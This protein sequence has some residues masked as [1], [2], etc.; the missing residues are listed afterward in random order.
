MLD[1]EDKLP[2]KRA[3]GPT[4][5]MTTATLCEAT[6]ESNMICP[7]TCGCRNSL[8]DIEKKTHIVSQTLRSTRLIRKDELIAKPEILALKQ[9]QEERNL[10]VYRTSIQYTILGNIHGKEVYLVPPQDAVLL[11]QDRISPGLRKQLKQ[12][13]TVEGLGQFAN[14]TC[15]DTHWNANLEVAAVDHHEET[16]SE[17]M[18]ILR[19][20]NDIEPDTEILTRYWHT[21]K[22]AWHNIFVC[23]CCACTNHT[24][25]APNPPITTAAGRTLST[26]IRP[27]REKG[28]PESRE[29]VDTATT[30]CD[31]KRDDPEV[32]ILEYPDS[33]IDE[34]NWDELEVSPSISD[35]IL[36]QPQ[37]TTVLHNSLVDPEA[38][39]RV[40]TARGI[41]RPTADHPPSMSADPV[42]R[43]IGKPTTSCD[44]KSDVPGEN[45]PEYLDSEIDDWNW[46]ELEASPSIGEKAL[47]QPQINTHPLMLTKGTVYGS[48]FG[49]YRSHATATQ[50]TMSHPLLSSLL[51]KIAQTPQQSFPD[52]MP[53]AAG[54]PVTIY[55]GGQPQRW[56]VSHDG[57]NS[58]TTVTLKNKD[59]A[60]IVDKSWVTFDSQVGTHVLQ[61]LGFF[62]DSISK[63]TTNSY[64]I[65]QNIL[66]P[67]KM[68]NGETLMVLLE[69]TIHGSPTIEALGLPPAPNTTWLVDRSFWQ[70][71]EQNNKPLPVSWEGTEWVCV[72]QEPI[73]GTVIDHVE[74]STTLDLCFS[75]SES[76]ISAN[77]G[78]SPCRRTLLDR[79]MPRTDPVNLRL[80]T[81]NYIIGT[82]GY[83]M[84][85]ESFRYFRKIERMIEK[86]TPPTSIHLLDHIIIPINV[87]HSHWFPAHINLRR[88][89]FSFLDSYQH[90]SAASY[91]QQEMLTWKF[92]K[93]AWTTHVQG[94]KPG[95]QWVI[96][97]EKFIKLHPRLTGLTPTTTQMP[98]KNSQTPGSNKTEMINAQ[99]KREWA[100][101]GIR[102]E[103]IGPQS[104]DQLGSKWT[105]LEQTGTP[106]QNNFT[107]TTETRLACGIY[108]VLNRTCHHKRCNSTSVQL[109]TTV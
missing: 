50:H 88:Q 99:P 77:D 89:S 102:S 51:E 10:D 55:T 84:P 100:R 13:N 44:S 31:S 82:G 32:N 80:M 61:R 2:P 23:Q 52:M 54:T 103:R 63:R 53:I 73:W 11:L 60:I 107:N 109:W 105:M 8:R 37:K 67:D 7:T 96:P 92:L 72:D 76:N 97:P 95:P 4:R 85:S 62:M 81:D 1:P 18:G 70:S 101:R 104:A 26:D 108:T 86:I 106:Q 9:A 5:G 27:L 29:R 90:Y 14:H 66:N 68:M 20:K 17:P 47:T 38:H 28:D 34:W 19:A 79:P 87:L 49:G 40:I 46:D 65:W 24:G 58:D 83:Y 33:E 41:P 91:P 21:K 59:C 30:S 56:K 45:T 39:G 98:L 94:A 93:M 25:L 42:T 78:H 16:K 64:E 12:H 36:T 3:R 48:T 74:M 57:P 71:W 69:W 35:T 75:K 43:E 6:R 15:C 22:D